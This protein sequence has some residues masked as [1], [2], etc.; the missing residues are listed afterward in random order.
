MATTLIENRTR[1][2]NLKRCTNME[3]IF[4]LEMLASDSCNPTEA[5]RNARYK[6]PAQAAAKLLKKPRIKA[7]LGK[8]KREREERTQITSDEV[9]KYLHRVLSFDPADILTDAGD[10]WWYLKD[11]RTIPKEIRQMIESHEPAVMHLGEESY[12]KCMKVKFV[13]KTTALTTAARHA[14]PPVVQQHEVVVAN[15]DYKALYQDQK[16]AED[17]LEKRLLLEEGRRKQ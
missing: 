1:G 11:L 13:S 10:G 16:N 8:A 7:L 12:E 3:R 14:L 6:H 17:P 5:A 15:I 2:A 4:V 9:W